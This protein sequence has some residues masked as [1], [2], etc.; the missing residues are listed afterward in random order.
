RV[1]DDD[2]VGVEACEARTCREA[3]EICLGEQTQAGRRT[4][5]ATPLLRAEILRAVDVDVAETEST[6]VGEVGCN[7]VH[8]S[9]R[10]G[11]ELNGDPQVLPS[12]RPHHGTETVVLQRSPP[13]PGADDLAD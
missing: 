11:L 12:R 10:V 1:V 8:R 2:V 3:D 6:E 7:R 13:P 5:H 9:S 4:S